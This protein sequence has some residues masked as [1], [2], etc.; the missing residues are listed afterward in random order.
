MI[1]HNTSVLSHAGTSYCVAHVVRKEL[2]G[3]QVNS[4]SAR[5][6]NVCTLLHDTPKV[7]FYF[8]SISVY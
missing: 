4:V 6:S 2:L 1:L 3:R 8:R 5:L 7:T